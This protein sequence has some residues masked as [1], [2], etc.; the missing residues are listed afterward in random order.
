MTCM[1]PLIHVLGIYNISVHAMVGT[2]E[3]NMLYGKGE[4][5]YIMK[6]FKGVA[7][8]LNGVL[9]IVLLSNALS[10]GQSVGFPDVPIS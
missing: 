8:F 4:V 7:K 5:R 10:L 1:K 6:A 3:V 9:R 2:S